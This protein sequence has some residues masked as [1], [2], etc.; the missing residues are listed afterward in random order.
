LFIRHESFRSDAGRLVA[1]I[2]GVLAVA[3]GTV[4]QSP[5]AAE[6]EVPMVLRDDRTGSNA[7]SETARKEA[8]S[9]FIRVD[10]RVA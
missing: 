1:V 10:G 7:P 4:G 9:Y 5:P 2:E 8:V 3:S 6:A